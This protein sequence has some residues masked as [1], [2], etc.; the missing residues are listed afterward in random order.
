MLDG[1]HHNVAQFIASTSA[2]AVVAFPQS[3]PRLI[4]DARS[5]R[6]GDFAKWCGRGVSSDSKQ[7]N[8]TFGFSASSTRFI[9]STGDRRLR[10]F[11]L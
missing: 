4:D 1:R 9:A 2:M 11:V 10:R 5:S 3:W 6:N 7:S 8:Q